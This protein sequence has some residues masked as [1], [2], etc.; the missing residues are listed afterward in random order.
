MSLLLLNSMATPENSTKAMA[1]ERGTT[2]FPAA[3]AGVG[4]G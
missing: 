3:A 4:F 1:T 2:Q